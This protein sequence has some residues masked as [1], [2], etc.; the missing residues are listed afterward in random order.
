MAEKRV[1][2]RLAA[3]GGK[4]V[5]AEFEGIGEAGKRG[6]GKAS[7]EM[8]IANARLA[9]FARRAKIA[10]G[11]MAAAAVVAG[12][13]MVRSS[14]QSIDEQAK[15]A[16]SLRTT[17]A[18]LQI[19]SRAGDLAGV[20]MGEIEQAT[21]QLTKRLSQAAAGTGPAVDAL[22]QLRLSATD[23][24]G[25]TVDTKIAAIQDAIA[26]FI[27]SA[28]QAAIASQI[29]GDRAGLIFTRIDSATL[30]QATQD[31]QDFGVAVS[32]TDAAQIQ[33][34]N[35]AL[36]RMGLLWRG[37][38]NQLAVAAAPALEA[39]ANGLVSIGKT[40]GPL[41][42]SIKS[43]FD[44]IG[45]IVSI[46]ATFAIFMAGRFAKSMAVAALGIR[47]L[48]LSLATLKIA[49]IRT[50][51]GAL[52]VGLGELAYRLNLFSTSAKSGSEAQK[53]LNDALEVYALTSGPQARSEAVASAKAYI[54]ETKAKLSSAQAELTLAI[55]RR[56][57]GQAL[58][59]QNPLTKGDTSPGSYGAAMRE[60]VVALQT[61]IANLKSDL[62]Y[63]LSQ[64]DELAA[65]EPGKPLGIAVTSAN[66]LSAALGETTSR[67]AAL[68]SFLSGLPNAL[69]TATSKIAGL[70]ASIAVLADGGNA[71]A[72]AVAKY[73]AGL[74]AALPPMESMQD[75]QRAF[76]RQAIDGQVALFKA[77]QK[78]SAQEQKRLSALA[79]LNAAAGGAAR[80]AG[81]AARVAGEAA[82]AGWEGAGIT[83][84][85]YAADAAD[86]AKG[87]GAGLSR[88]FSSAESAIVQFV[89][90]GKLNFRD[91][92]SSILADLA[93]IMARKLILGPLANALGGVFS[94]FSG[95]APGTSASILH[96]GGMV[97]G[98]GLQRRVPAMVFAGAPR[99]HGGGYAGLR[100][101]EVPAILQR[102]ERVLSRREVAAG[103]GASQV[104]VRVFVDDDGRLG[105]IA[106]QEGAAAAR[107]VAVEVVQAG[108]RDYDANALPHRVRQIS[109]DPRRVG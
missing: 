90:T 86:V 44:N 91:F 47:G 50:G 107:P 9:R 12:I 76:V 109:V 49:L 103:A 69:N 22:K 55:A 18:S 81:E 89:K 2:V 79:G 88:A 67:A 58:L 92:T 64:L 54:E 106:R 62:N 4:Q 56:T 8:E 37:I 13:A 5:R 102:G 59:D 94:L 10:A 100:P 36:T 85:S 83:L 46:S 104:T 78:L 98:G 99:M 42:R 45:E 1:S 25:L 65:K 82:K 15:L 60:N 80:A 28:Q 97:G 31:V 3:V 30:R 93:K 75:G 87:I 70:K 7:R 61:A 33:R 71:A 20:S 23:L 19:L 66:N 74:V 27:P 38:A 57:A 53:R 39:V 52:I 16:A 14:L 68:S 72:A 51:V 29:F 17:T 40:T 48:S 35:D 84:A 26:K 43:L 77:E 34:T 108:I 21:I 41:G 95:P 73:R 101:D 63:T 11:I 105:A 6:F 24:E 96:S 32:K